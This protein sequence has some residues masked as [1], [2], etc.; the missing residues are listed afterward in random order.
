MWNFYPLPIL[1]VT[2][3]IVI[4]IR[5]YLD[6]T[7]STFQLDSFSQEALLSYK[8]SLNPKTYYTSFLTS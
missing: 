4:K 8:L 5:F 7:Q 1:R 6:D 3:P 2:K